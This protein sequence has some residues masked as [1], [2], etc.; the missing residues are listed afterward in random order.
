MTGMRSL[1]SLLVLRPLHEADLELDRAFLERPRDVLVGQL[2]GDNNDLQFLNL[3]ECEF[4]SER[5]L[6]VPVIKAGGDRLAQNKAI[7]I[8]D[9]LRISS[10]K[11]FPIAAISAMTAAASVESIVF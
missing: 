10:M 2:D 3:A 1:R 4:R 8:V 6:R 9:H 11:M 7:H 5:G